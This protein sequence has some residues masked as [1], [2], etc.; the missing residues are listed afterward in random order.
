MVE[1]F[2]LSTLLAVFFLSLSPSYSAAVLLRSR[3]AGIINAVTRLCVHVSPL[4]YLVYIRNGF[5]NLPN[6]HAR[7]TEW[8][9]CTLNMLR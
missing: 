6:T 2:I 9:V 5:S 7:S 3:T 1:N 8:N 4:Y